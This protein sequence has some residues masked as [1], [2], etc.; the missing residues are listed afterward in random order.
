[1]DE[2]TVDEGRYRRT[3]HDLQYSPILTADF[4]AESTKRNTLLEVPFQLWI[5]ATLTLALS[6]GEG[7]K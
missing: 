1:M 4:P 5:S 7:V 3:E 6:N 2:I